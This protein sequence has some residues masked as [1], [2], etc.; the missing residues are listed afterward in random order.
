MSIRI[1][2]IFLGLLYVYFQYLLGIEEQLFCIFATVFFIAC[3]WFELERE[4]AARNQLCKALQPWK[5]GLP[6]RLW[7]TKVWLKLYLADC[8]VL[9]QSLV[10]LRS[11]SDNNHLLA[12]LLP[13][14]HPEYYLCAFCPRELRSKGG[15]MVAIWYLKVKN[16][17]REKIWSSQYLV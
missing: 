15:Q 9:P 11:Q 2:V 14:H 5:G 3:I 4:R 17:C 6:N 13:W 16:L 8:Q 1:E 7:S 10:W 12:P